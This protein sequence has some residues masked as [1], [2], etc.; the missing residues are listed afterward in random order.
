M[1]YCDECDSFP[2]PNHPIW[3]TRRFGK[4]QCLLKMPMMFIMPISPNDYDW[5]FCVKSCRAFVKK[6]YNQPLNHEREKA[7]SNSGSSK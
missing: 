7:E 2:P 4:R 6:E 5:G 3:E 1:I